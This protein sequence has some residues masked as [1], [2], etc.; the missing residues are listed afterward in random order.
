MTRVSCIPE[1]LHDREEVTNQSTPQKPF[2]VAV[3][4]DLPESTRRVTEAVDYLLAQ[5]VMPA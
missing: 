2:I 4:N 1:K 5:G 3:R